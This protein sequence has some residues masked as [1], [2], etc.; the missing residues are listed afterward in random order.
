MKGTLSNAQDIQKLVP[1][2]GM[3][4]LVNLLTPVL[5]AVGLFIR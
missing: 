5:V 2:M 3:N 1:S 4:V